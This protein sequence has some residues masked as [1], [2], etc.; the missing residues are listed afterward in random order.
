MGQ[1]PDILEI[2]YYDEENEVPVEENTAFGIF[3][4]DSQFTEMVPK[5]SKRIAYSLGYPVNDLEITHK[6]IYVNIETAMLEFSKIMNEFKTEEDYFSLFGKN[7]DDVHKHKLVYPNLDY[8]LRLSSAYGT[9]AGV[10]GDVEFH[11]GKIQ[12]Q[13]GK[14]L[15]DLKKE[16]FTSKHP[17][18][19]SFSIRKVYHY[20]TPSAVI[21]STAGNFVG[22]ESV[23]SLAGEFGFSGSSKHYTLTPMSWDV[24]R[25]QSVNMARKIRTSM[26]GFSIRGSQLRLFPI[27]KNDFE[28]HFDY[29]LSSEE[30][31][32]NNKDRRYNEDSGDIVNDPTKIDF[33]VFQWS[34][35]SP[36]HQTWIYNYSEALVKITLGE[37]RRKFASLQYPNGEISLNG[38][39]LVSEGK[40]EIRDLKESMKEY[41]DK[42]SKERGIDIDRQVTEAQ[43]DKLRKIPL[44]IYRM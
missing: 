27:P 30:Q 44:G 32:R 8:Y 10:G 25:M 20:R 19:N 6:N 22:I 15:Y 7:K 33:G 23:N 35:L 3:D 24:Q 31:G 28:L 21:G 40:E 42:L 36:T 43:A 1:A 29:T 12:V 17:A 9:E 13:S 16:Y 18:E 11:S 38:D 2:E 34:E 37:N 41:L 4:N 5:L 14:Q 39:A 26:Y